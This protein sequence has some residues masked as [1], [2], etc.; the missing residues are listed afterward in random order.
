M[1]NRFY[2]INPTTGWAVTTRGGI[3]KTTDAGENWFAQLNAG[4][5]I[6]FS[7]IHFVDSLY[8]WTANSNARPYK[9]TDGGNNWVH[10]SN[11]NIGFSRDIYFKNFLNG[12]I[13]ESNKLYKSTDAGLTWILNPDVTGYSIAARISHYEDI[14]VITGFTTYRS[15]NSGED[16]EEFTELHGVR[17]NGLSLLSGGFGYAVGELGLVLKYFDKD[18]PVELISFYSELEKNTVTLKWITATETNNKG[19]FVQ[20]KKEYEADWINLAFINGAGTSI[21]INNYHYNNN[22]SSFGKYQYRLKQIDFNGQYDYSSETEVEYTNNL[23]FYLSQ[24]YP[25]PFNPNTKIRWQVPIGCKQT[26][27]IYDILGK[28]IATLVDEYRDAGFYEVEF[29]TNN[30]ANINAGSINLASGVYIY[31][32]KAGEYIS[33]RKMMI[34]K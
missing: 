7:G 29:N 18:V 11:I 14:I 30:S 16:W 31:K 13:V 32:L 20:R 25:N 34:L 9:T 12:F 15:I 24:N 3:L 27:K 17:I 5:N 2:F 28:E 6:I 19:F 8:G 26:L 21:S 10:Q 23:D 22:L 1:I 4:I 33:S